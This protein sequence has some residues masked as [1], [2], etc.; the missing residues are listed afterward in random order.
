[1][2]HI[3]PSLLWLLGLRKVQ[4]LILSPPAGKWLSQ[5]LDLGLS[6]AKTQTVASTLNFLQDSNGQ[7]RTVSEK[8]HLDLSV[9]LFPSFQIEGQSLLPGLLGTSA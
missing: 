3:P 5:D 4:L 6:D 8:S 2:I 7:R 9:D 1:M